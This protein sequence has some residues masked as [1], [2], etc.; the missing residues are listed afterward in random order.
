MIQNPDHVTGVVR[1]L[2]AAKRFFALLDFEETMAVVIKG[3]RFADYMGLDEIEAD[4]VTLVLQGSD[5]RFEMQLLHYRKPEI[6]GDDGVIPLDRPGFNH[7]C[8]A[9]D[10]MDETI[11][12]L[13]EAGLEV[14]KELDVFHK[15]RLVFLTGPEGI[16]IELAEWM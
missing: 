13:K 6:A 9:V 5:P 4:H 12:R 8:F 1:D 15:R 3:D 2:D 10:N 14:R 7:L 16:T 11:G